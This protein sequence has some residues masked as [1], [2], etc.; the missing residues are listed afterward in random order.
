MRRG[1][2]GPLVRAFTGD[3][4]GRKQLATTAKDPQ[5][6]AKGVDA[7]PQRGATDHCNCI[8]APEDAEDPDRRVLVDDVRATLAPNAETGGAAAFEARRRDGLWG[9]HGRWHAFVWTNAAVF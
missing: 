1:H 7:S 8:I 5:A 9:Y 3:R 2:H 6:R 4:G